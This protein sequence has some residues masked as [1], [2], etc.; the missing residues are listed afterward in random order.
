MTL[1][2]LS[3][4]ARL[5]AGFGI[6]VALLVI[7]S[8][9]AVVRMS[10]IEGRL[11]DIVNV[12]MRK[13][14]LLEDMSKSVHIVQR[15]IRT[16]ILLHDPVAI[17]RESEK[18][19]AARIRYDNAFAELEK[20]SAS[21][22][23]R[24]LRQ[25]THEIQ[26]RVRPL[27][28]EILE[29]ARVGKDA[30]ATDL[31]VSKGIA[32][33]QQWLDV[34]EENVELQEK[35]TAK[36]AAEARDAY[37]SARITT[38]TLALLAIAS[39][40]AAGYLITTSL[41]RQLGGE[42]GYAAEVAYRIASGDLA[43]DVA[44]RPGDESS[45]LYAM[46]RMRSSLAEIVA[47]VRAGTDSM[48]SAATQIAT[49]NLDLS[50]RTEEQ[51]SSLEET[52]SSMEELTST[53]KQNADNARQANA[54]ASTA[55]RV[56]AEGGQ[57]VQSVVHTMGAIHDASTKIVDIIAVIDG[58][59]FQTNILA[60]NAAVEAARAGEQGRGF[61]VVATEVRTLAQRSANA[62][63]EIRHLIDNSVTQVTAGTDQVNRAGATMEEVVASVK[64]VTDIISE[65]ST[66]SAEQTSGIEQINQAITQMDDVTQQNASL[67]EEAAAAS[68]AMQEQ[69][70]KLSDLVSIFRLDAASAAARSSASAAIP[71]RRP[72][73]ASQPAQLPPP[74]KTTSLR[75]PAK[76]AAGQ[77]SS[78][79]A[80]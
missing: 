43:V 18:I 11:D 9:M 12:N 20:T 36:E 72:A 24:A 3:V 51:A 64:R 26:D 30:E 4:R 40:I 10:Q 14:T 19:T 23:G 34:L 6:V 59:A 56:A 27:N 17:Q 69:A 25:K 66:A 31:L 2:H 79:R 47:E 38:V 78:L 39:A 15:V 71:T 48:A 50:S 70:H 45:M 49:G 33:N 80:A 67:V 73:K 57:V 58:I 5:A 63:K 41:T 37:D 35:V 8:S 13:M 68:E 46:K 1:Q 54:L 32:L 16:I 55:S 62:A 42:P 21:E 44:V 74:A 28:S 7:I 29:L 77:A 75:L 22:A 53:V 52:A 76:P 65:I 60:L 61:A